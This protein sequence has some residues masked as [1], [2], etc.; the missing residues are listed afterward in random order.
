MSL[1]CMTTVLYNVKKV[2]PAEKLL[3]LIIADHAQDE[4]RCW[5]GLERLA[6]LS[7]LSRMTV[8]RCIQSLEDK[9]ELYVDRNWGTR[10]SNCYHLVCITGGKYGSPTKEEIAAVDASLNQPQGNTMIPPRVTPCDGGNK[11]IPPPETLGKPP[12]LVTPRDGGNTM[13]PSHPASQMLPEPVRTRDKQEERGLFCAPSLEDVI[14]AAAA[15]PG[16]EALHLAAGCIT[17]AWA[18]AHF[19]IRALEQEFWSPDWKGAMYALY[20]NIQRRRQ[21]AAAPAPAHVNGAAQKRPRWSVQKELEA[22][23]E[24]IITHPR[25]RRCI[26]WFDDPV[27]DAAL[28]AL[29]SKRL[30]LKKELDLL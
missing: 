26:P 19:T 12:S 11:M 7:G 25:Y 2:S 18:K 9:G 14:A 17:Q 5:P 28:A 3:L 27:G 6:E 4:G 30:E 23:E 21:Q 15:Y 8:I 24:R 29:K 16:N 20:E 13:I 22:L 1:L 10:R